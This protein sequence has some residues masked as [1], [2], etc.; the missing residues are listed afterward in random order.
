MAN[1]RLTFLP[2]SFV[3]AASEEMV[4]LRGYSPPM[5]QEKGERTGQAVSFEALTSVEWALRYHDK[6]SLRATDVSLTRIP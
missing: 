2:L 1:T 5:L 6:T 4:A 3:D